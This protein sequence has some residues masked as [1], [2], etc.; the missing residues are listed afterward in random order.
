MVLLQRRAVPSAALQLAVRR[1]EQRE[2]PERVRAR[3]AAHRR[4][5]HVELRP[6]HRALPRVSAGAVEAGRAVFSAAADYPAARTLRLARRRAALRPVVCVDRRQ[7]DG[8]QGDLRPI[9]FRAARRQ[10]RDTSAIFNRND[11][12][13]HAVSLERSE[14]QPASL[15]YP[16]ASSATSSRPR[17]DRPARVFNPDMQQ[18]KTDEVTVHRRA[19]DRGRISA[20]VG[21]VLQEANRTSTAGQHRAPVRRATTS[22]SRP[23]IRART[24]VVGTPTMVARSPTTTTIR[25]IAGAA[26]ETAPT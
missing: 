8:R 23:S 22:R 11:Y 9:Q 4:S 26:F 1:R 20:R 7:E 18:P 12:V 13:G 17:A 6:A 10:T 5:A 15:D 24:A 2:L 16:P 14:Q 21:Y 25:P 3:H 19:R